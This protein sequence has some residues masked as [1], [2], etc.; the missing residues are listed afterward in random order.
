M[1]RI[2]LIKLSTYCCVLDNLSN[3]S[4]NWRKVWI[5]SLAYA[6]S[7]ILE[8]MA[9]RSWRRHIDEE[10]HQYAASPEPALACHLLKMHL[11]TYY[12]Q[13]CRFYQGLDMLRRNTIQYFITIINNPFREINPAIPGPFPRS[14]PWRGSRSTTS[15]VS[16]GVT[17]LK[18]TCNY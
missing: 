18:R 6:P 3:L 10:R 9:L 8:E 13:F 17:T 14:L 16:F 5:K 1:R 12:Q 7:C 15:V 2:Q 4:T 11:K